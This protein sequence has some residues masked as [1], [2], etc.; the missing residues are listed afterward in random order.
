MTKRSI[1]FVTAKTSF[2]VKTLMGNLVKKSFECYLSDYSEEVINSHADIVDAIV[3]FVEQ[4][5]RLL[6]EQTIEYFN[7]LCLSN[8]VRL[9]IVGDKADME[10]LVPAFRT[11]ILEKIFIR[12][13]NVMD[14]SDI[15]VFCFD[16]VEADAKKKHILVVDDSGNFLYTIKEWLS[17]YYKV[18]VV[19]SA[20]NAMECLKKMNVDLVLLD[21]EMPECDGPTL[22]GMIRD[23]QEFNSMPVFFLTGKGD[24]KSI[25]RVLS[26]NPQGYLLKSLPKD[27][28]VANIKEYFDKQKSI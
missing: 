8:N 24:R 1:L 9:F 27:K 18:T 28:V 15:I 16:K 25:E 3:L 22:L 4:D 5:R 2:L 19:S 13:I 11:E 20:L 17:P 21:Y 12:P 7:E 10:V 6:S 23:T 26:L 14:V